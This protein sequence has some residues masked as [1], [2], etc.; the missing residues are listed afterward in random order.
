MH[1]PHLKKILLLLAVPIVIAASFWSFGAASPPAIPKVD[2]SSEPLFA[3]ATLD[4]PTL[5]LALSVEFPTVGA[6]YTKTPGNEYD[7]SYTNTNEYLGYYDANTCYKYN[8]NPSETI[9][10]G[11]SIEDYRRFD[12]IGPASNRKCSDAFS[13]NFLNWATSS[14]VDMLRMSLAG[15]DRYI[16]N[17]DTTILQRAV[18]PNG[19]PTCMWRSSY[20]PLKQLLRGD[21]SYSGAVPVMMRNKAFESRGLWPSSWRNGDIW[22][23]NT[24][25]QVYFGT[26]Q[27]TGD[28]CGFVTTGPNNYYLGS[29]SSIESV[30]SFFTG[31]TWCANENRR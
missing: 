10:S 8:D 30:S 16:D 22:I 27:S 29:P 19:D 11:K 20:F 2:L 3:T 12:P 5:A 14:A 17:K 18:L 31:N 25:N 28:D 1:I 26:D 4:K 7:D 6:Q 13:G 24:M 21:G 15:G 23:A 9:E